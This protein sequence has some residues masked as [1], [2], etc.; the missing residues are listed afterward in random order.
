ML[1]RETLQRAAA[2]DTEHLQKAEAPRPGPTTL[3]V[4]RLDRRLELFGKGP[5][6]PGLSLLQQL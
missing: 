3:P 2:M 5:L 6:Q 1:C 4:C